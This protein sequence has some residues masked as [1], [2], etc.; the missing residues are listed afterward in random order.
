MQAKINEYGKIK[1]R[2][3]D[4]HGINPGKL[5]PLERN[6]EIA[7]NEDKAIDAHIA[8]R[9]QEIAHPIVERPDNRIA[10]ENDDVYANNHQDTNNA[11]KLELRLTQSWP[12]RLRLRQRS[13]NINY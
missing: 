5:S 2:E 8:K 7:R 12:Q 10:T 11:E 13:H 6:A 4:N 3:K 1:K 9:Q